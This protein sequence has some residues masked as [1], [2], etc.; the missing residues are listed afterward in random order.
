M[1]REGAINNLLNMN[2]HILVDFSYD[3]YGDKCI[4]WERMADIYCCRS[5]L[6]DFWTTIQKDKDK[7][8][9][10]TLYSLT[11]VEDGKETQRIKIRNED[12]DKWLHYIVDIP[13]ATKQMQQILNRYE[14]IVKNDQY[15]CFESLMNILQSHL[16][17]LKINFEKANMYKDLNDAK[18][19]QTIQDIFSQTECDKFNASPIEF[20]DFC[21]FKEKLSK[22]AEENKN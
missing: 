18:L 1:D 11:L 5:S 7:H 8:L 16:Y 10:D 12:I 4:S 3:N 20:F 6:N 17:A 13:Y 9:D 21:K 14:K 22:I 19:K 2:N 15:E